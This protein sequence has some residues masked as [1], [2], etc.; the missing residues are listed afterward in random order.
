MYRNLEL[1]DIVVNGEV[2]QW[3]QINK[4]EGLS[5]F[6]EYY[7][8]SNFGRV[9]SVRGREEKI[10][11]QC[12]NSRGYLLVG[13]ATLDGKPKKMYVH[14][15]VGFAFVSGWSKELV[16]NHLDEDKKNNHLDNLEWCTIAENNA[17]GTRT[18][19]VAEKLSMP[20][21][22]VCVTT[23]EVIEFPSTAEAHRNGFDKSHISACCRG[24]GKTHKGF[25][26]KY[27]ESA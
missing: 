15:L 10:M 8:V 17:Y 6:K 18:I 20:V 1:E 12:D 24:E 21:I 19:R 9:K 11:K 27:K 5:E 2:E 25:K 26:W 4:V 7:W 13:L 3:K 22:G 16:C 23:G 14:R